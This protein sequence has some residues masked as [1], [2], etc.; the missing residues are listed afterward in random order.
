MS[1]APHL[2]VIVGA[3]QVIQRPGPDGPA[4]DARGPV[5]LMAEAARAAAADAGAP[6]LLERVAW[7]GAVP[8][9]YRHDNPGAQL[10]E[11]LGCPTART[12]LSGHSGTSALDLLGVACARIAAGQLDVALV[13][14]GEA[15]WS[16]SRFK[17]HGRAVPWLQDPGGLPAPERVAGFPDEML[18]ET[19]VFGSPTGA[20]AL[21]EDRLRAEAGETP[22]EHTARIAALWARF[23]AVAADNPYAWDRTPHS[24]EAI[25]AIGPRNRM[26]ATPYPKAMV[27]N[28]TV[29][30]GSALV[31]CSAGAARA[32]GVAA[33]RFV[34]PHVI[35]HAH[36]TWQVVNRRE[37]HRS[38][39]LAVAGQV[40]FERAGVGPDDVAHVDLYACFPSIVQMSTAALGLAPDRPLTLTGGLGFAGAP[41]ANAV[42]QSLAAMVPCVRQGGWA[43]VHGNGGY[44]TKQSFGIFH[45]EP[46]ADGF[47]DVDVQD[48]V[49]LDPRPALAPGWS[50]SVTVEA[51]TV[52][53]DRD[54]PERAVAATLDATGAR[55]WAVS[56]DP[57]TMSAAAGGALTGAP[58]VRGADGTLRV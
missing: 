11:V 10:G 49:D 34:F 15:R 37:L 14:G 6:G 7:I 28:N 35:T 45:A 3:A 56:R 2:P 26:I 46:P 53:Y 13:V 47:A 51:A 52:L 27:A 43:L 55:G 39:A 40:A 5:E 17:A 29:D 50:G 54:G 38:P 48:R 30:M 31:V 21:F 33:D 9:W 12:A 41:I 8:G 19:E 44:A 57:A 18:A 58:A 36:E 23:S 1:A 24:A 22:A 20:Y 4:G 25:A 42:G 16:A 32:A